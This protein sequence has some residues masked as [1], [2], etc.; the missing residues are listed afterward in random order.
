MQIFCQGNYRSLLL[1]DAISAVMK[2]IA[3]NYQ[4]ITI[5]NFPNSRPSKYCF[6]TQI[7]F[8]FFLTRW[9]HWIH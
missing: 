7:V 8:F 1:H 4:I 2:E 9:Y 5:F 3:V 6:E